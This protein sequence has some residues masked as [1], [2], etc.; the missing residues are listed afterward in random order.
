MTGKQAYENDLRKRPF[1]PDGMGKR[2]EWEKLS[3]IAQWSWNRP[4]VQS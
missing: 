2:P 1:Y 3:A 4:E